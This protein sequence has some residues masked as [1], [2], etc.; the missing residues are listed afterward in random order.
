MNNEGARVRLMKNLPEAQNKYNDAITLNN[1]VYFNQG[2][3]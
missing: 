3:Y 2:V 1:R